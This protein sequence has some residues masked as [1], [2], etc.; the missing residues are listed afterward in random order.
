MILW[1]EW[2][3]WLVAGIGLAVFEV[4]VPGYVFVGFAI[5]AMLTALAVA[6]GAAA[7]P[8]S[9]VVLIFALTSLVAWLLLRQIF[10]V[11]RGQRKIWDRDINED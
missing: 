7:A 11:R 4:L 9:V 10:G 5:G 3:V 1:Q 6:L 2:W 8:L